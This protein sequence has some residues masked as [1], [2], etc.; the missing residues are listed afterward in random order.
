MLPCFFDAARKAI[1][2]IRIK[3]FP[4]TIS[5]D[6]FNNNIATWWGKDPPRFSPAHFRKIQL[7]TNRAPV[8]RYPL[9]GGRLD[10]ATARPCIVAAAPTKSCGM[11]IPRLTCVLSWQ[12][13]RVSVSSRAERSNLHKIELKSFQV[14]KHRR[15][16]ARAGPPVAPNAAQKNIAQSGK[17]R[18]LLSTPLSPWERGAQ[19]A[20]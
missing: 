8:F 9:L 3:R 15:H 2:Y 6:D 18:L 14:T 17:P 13:S 5:G 12:L 19:R 4:T 7:I 16:P 10:K 11:K 1:K 20:G